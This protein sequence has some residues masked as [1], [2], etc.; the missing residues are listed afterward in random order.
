MAWYWKCSVCGYE[1]LTVEFNPACINCGN[2]YNP[3]I[4]STYWAGD[5][6]PGG[7][8]PSF[9]NE[10]EESRDD[11]SHIDHTVPQEE[12]ETTQGEGPMPFSMLWTL[13]FLTKYN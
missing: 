9:P 11:P 12:A 10:Q 6:E 1:P 4:D 13:R 2:P 7:G 8:I 3:T 5:F